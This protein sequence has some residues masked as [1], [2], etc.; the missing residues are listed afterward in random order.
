MCYS[1]FIAN[2]CIDDQTEVYKCYKWRMED[3]LKI[4]KKEYFSNHWLD[5]TQIFKLSLGGQTKVYKYVNWRR[6]PIAVESCVMTRT[7]G[8]M[9]RKSERK[10]RVWLCSA[11]LVFISTFPLYLFYKIFQGCPELFLVS[12][13]ICFF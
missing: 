2:L 11:Q 7:K 8:E 10:S 13:L 1:Q 6:P 5:H 3:D 12:R 4:L 9:H